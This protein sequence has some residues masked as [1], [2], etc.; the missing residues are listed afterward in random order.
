MGKFLLING[1]PNEHGCTYTALHELEKAL[2]AEGMETEWVFL[3]N[4]PQ[5]GCTACMTCQSTGEC[6]FDD[7]V[8]DI[9][10]RL[11]TIDGIIAGSPVY[12]GCPSGPL[13]SF[14]DRLCLINEYRLYRKLAASVLSCRR[15]G[16]SGAFMALNQCFLNCS[17]TI[18][19]SEYWN[20]VHGMAP[21]EVAGDPEGLQTMRVLGQNIAWL[22]KSIEAGRSAGIEAP[23]Y[24]KRI[25]TNF[26]R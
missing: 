23:V 15:G 19:G 20:Q 24:E 4:E 2:Q 11:D 22:Q 13:L 6:I 21:E 17:M 3:G 1:S 10:R 26:V 12:Y 8:N 18:V 5:H 14:L 7:K 25:Y 9:T 16:A